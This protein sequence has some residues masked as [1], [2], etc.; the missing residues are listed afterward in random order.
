MTRAPQDRCASTDASLRRDSLQLS[1]AI[2]RGQKKTAQEIV[3]DAKVIEEYLSS[4][5]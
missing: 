4:G 3:A 2:N 5:K 1:E